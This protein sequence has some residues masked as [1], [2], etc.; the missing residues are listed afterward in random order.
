MHVQAKLEAAA[1]RI[2][3]LLSEQAARITRGDLDIAGAAWT[4]RPLA[5][6]HSALSLNESSYQQASPCSTPHK[7]QRHVEQLT[8]LCA[9]RCHG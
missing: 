3:K 1:S 8:P 5:P 4:L 9:C 7:G 2:G 6:S